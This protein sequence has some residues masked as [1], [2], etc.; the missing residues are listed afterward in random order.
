MNL[1]GTVVTVIDLARRL[2]LPAGPPENRCIVV[3]HRGGRPVGLVVDSVQDVVAVDETEIEQPRE[4]GE[5]SRSELV[6]GIV[7]LESGPAVLLD[8]AQLV[9]QV[10]RS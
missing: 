3:M 5:Q 10:L 2:E 1:R 4:G 9:G 6:R 8:M 7:R